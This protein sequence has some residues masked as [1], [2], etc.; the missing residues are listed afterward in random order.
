MN[1]AL[2]DFDGT[3]TVADSFTPFIY[4]AASRTRTALGTLLL[5]PMI[6]GYRLGLVPGTRMRA[7]VAR[8]CFWRRRAAEVQALGVAYSRTLQ[9]LVRPEALDKIRWHQQNGDVVVVVSA[10]LG[11]YLRA[12][13]EEHGLDLICTELEAE[14][15]V[16]TGRYAGGDC[17]A[18]EKARRVLS[19][20]DVSQYAVVYAYGDTIEDNELLGLASKRYLRWQELAA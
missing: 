19:R 12:W 1:L 13:C 16:L 7:A 5:S 17:T 11:V 3:I 8:V 9:R 6:L 10:S 20:Y 14:Q 2:F 15:G 4:L 18:G